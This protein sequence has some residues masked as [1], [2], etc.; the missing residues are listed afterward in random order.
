MSESK[1]VPDLRSPNTPIRNEDDL[2]VKKSYSFDD[3]VKGLNPDAPAVADRM[4]QRLMLAV[5]DE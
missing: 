5:F 2:T 4:R 1:A 3:L